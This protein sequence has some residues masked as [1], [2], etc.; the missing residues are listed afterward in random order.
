MELDYVHLGLY[1]NGKVL[2]SNLTQDT[3]YPDWGF[4]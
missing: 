4:L 2:G 3:G 1:F